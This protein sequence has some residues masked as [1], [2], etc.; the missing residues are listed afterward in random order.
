M[1]EKYIR[2]NHIININTNNPNI[3][4]YDIKKKKII[5]INF[6]LKVIYHHHEIHNIKK[7]NNKIEIII[8]NFF[9]IEK[10]II[11]RI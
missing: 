3:N 2:Y 10:N 6:L 9:H 7:Y 8:K 11:I 1:T 5:W 4:I